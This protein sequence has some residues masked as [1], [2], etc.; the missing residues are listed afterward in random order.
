MLD[1]VAV[2]SDPA[3]LA[4]VSPD[5]PCGPDLDLAGDA[6][7]LNFVAATEGAFPGNFYDFIRD[8][9]EFPVALETAE[10]L[11][12]RTL[13]ARLVILLAKLSI[14]NRNVS[15]FARW[16]ASLAWL[17][18]EHWDGAHPRA[19]EGDHSA[20]LGQLMTLEDNSVVLLPLQYAPL[21]ETLREG[22]LTYR[23]Q[24]VA[25]G[26][27]QP[28]SVT[29]MDER[30]E[31]QTSAEEKFISAK[32]IEKLL[33]E[34]EL[35]KLSGALESLRRLQ[36]AVESIKATTIERVGRADAVQLPE[37]G[38]LV[39]DMAAFLYGALSARDPT[40][41]PP[42]AAKASGEAI[43]GAAAEGPEAAPTAFASLAEVDAALASALGYFAGSEPS[44]PALILI[45]QARETL[46]KNLYDVMKLLAPSHADAARI[47]VGPVGAFTVPVSSLSNAPGVEF[48]HCEA[49]PA[50]NRAAALALIESVTA[51]MRRTEPSSPAPY[52]LD[53]AKALGSRDFAGLLRDLLP[54]D[55]LDS[56]KKGR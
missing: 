11:L 53:R 4:P 55:N 32:A 44:S 41:A 20:R 13:D 26:A 38:K 52:L 6:E 18:R 12:K 45:H 1:S 7:Y 48:T 5:D 33:R 21:I 29:R 8:S 37:L 14:L 10:K 9:I 35:D 43:E 19:E 46:G 16:M 2:P 28:R 50:S 23:A 3:A 24:L 36:A 49:E 42:A 31:Q 22:P 30:G 40:L 25:A 51:H 34:I 47:S 56:M 27:V 15:G 17:M 54:D 39:K